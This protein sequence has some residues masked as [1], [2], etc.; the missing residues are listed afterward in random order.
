MALQ[1]AE[2]VLGLERV[3]GLVR[4]SAATIAIPGHQF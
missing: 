2:Q 1:D 4:D 3:D